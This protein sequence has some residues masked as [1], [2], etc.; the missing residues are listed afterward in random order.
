VRSTDF[1]GFESILISPLAVE[2]HQGNLGLTAVYR[3]G[4]ANDRQRLPETALGALCVS[5]WALNLFDQVK[6]SAFGHAP[7]RFW[8]G[9]FPKSPGLFVAC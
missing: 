2:M 9:V 7:C 5:F 4:A 1:F 6:Q 3:A 8:T